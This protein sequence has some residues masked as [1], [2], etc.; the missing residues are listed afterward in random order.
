M[1]YWS[2][3][4]DRVKRHKGWVVAFLALVLVLFII[5][6]TVH[7]GPQ[8]RGDKMMDFCRF[9]L[10]TGEVESYPDVWVL[11][12]SVIGKLLVSGFLIGFVTDLVQ[13]S[14][15]TRQ[16]GTHDYKLKN[17][18][19]IAG[20]NHLTVGIVKQL[21]NEKNHPKDGSNVKVAI[22]TSQPVKRVRSEVNAS[23]NIEEQKHVYFY[24]GDINL[25]SQLQ[26]LNLKD[27]RV[28]YVLGEKDD[29]GRDTKNLECARLVNEIRNEECGESLELDATHPFTINV[30]LD[31]AS[32]FTSIQRLNIP[33]SYYSS[34][35]G[36]LTLF[37][38]PFNF[39]ENWAR[40]LW[41]YYV[42][43]DGRKPLYDRLDFERIAIDD[44][45]YVHLVIAGFDRMG[46][47]MCLEA[48]R[49][50]H[51]PN[52]K[53]CTGENKTVITVID[54]NMDT[55]KPAFEAQ[56]PYLNQI[57]D[58]KIEYRSCLFEDEA[59]RH[60]ISEWAKDPQQL[61]TIAIS[62]HDPDSSLSSALTLPADCFYQGY[63][64]N[65]N[66]KVVC[67]PA[68]NVRILIRQEMESVM[69]DVLTDNK[70]YT[71]VRTFGSP[72]LAIRN[73]L[74]DDEMPMWINWLFD[75]D[76]D[77]EKESNNEL[78][79]CNLEE[80]MKVDILLSEKNRRKA[81]KKWCMLNENLRFSN[82]YQV[83]M[84]AIYEDYYAALCSNCKD[85]K[86]KNDHL[87][88]L[89]QMEHLRWCAC[90]SII[91][92]KD[93]HK[94]N[95]KDNDDYLQHTLIVPYNSLGES[96]KMKDEAVILYREKVVDKERN[97]TR[98]Y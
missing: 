72:E 42:P 37:V 33:K 63:E 83:E 54:K 51:Y 31:S 23:L 1:E 89:Y 19:V 49:V 48:L 75:P 53:E 50:C 65:E 60:D 34:A 12:V 2:Y 55:I 81:L 90:R 67:K 56:F 35:S 91:G 68:T 41:G 47:A 24:A 38:R 79:E 80:T 88:I 70:K 17:H 15:E 22:L 39:Y 62:F 52:F 85:E 57:K 45:R 87:R 95:C 92:Y 73:E 97:R 94:D 96:D 44:K 64:R 21:L 29:L 26:R 3:I 69:K 66:D 7:W 4:K 10:N 93:A 16:N 71:N 30:E 20:Y 84:Y 8:D 74:L 36:K 61:L 28:V 9:F 40:T 14:Y 58:V 82:R 6:I 76:D 32:A 78:E 27:C 59:L 46:Q 11:I 5:H 86:E 25:K 98:D 13:Y 18:V 77:S 43:K